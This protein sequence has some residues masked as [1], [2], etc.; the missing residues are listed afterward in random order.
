MNRRVSWALTA[1]VLAVATFAGW[2][3]WRAGRYANALEAS[4]QTA[5]AKS[6]QN[7]E[8]AHV[9]LGKV[10]V[11]SSAADR[12]SLLDTVWYESRSAADEIGRLPLG[13]VNLAATR[14]FLNQ[15]GDYSHVLARMVAAGKPVAREHWDTL[16]RLHTELGKLA[17][18][19]HKVDARLTDG[20]VRWTRIM[21]PRWNRVRRQVAE[22]WPSPS[23][24]TLA[25]TQLAAAPGTNTRKSD[26]TPPV[27]ENLR[28][29]TDIDQHLQELPAMV[30]DGPFSETVMNRKPLGLTG[31]PIT[32][33]QAV[34]RARSYL[35]GAGVDTRDFRVEGRVLDI[36]GRI[37]SYQVTFVPTVGRG[38]VHAAISKKGGHLVWLLNDRVVG[39]PRLTVTQAQDSARSYLKAK[40]FG[41]V[42]PTYTLREDNTLLITFVAMQGDIRLY[43][44]QIK[45][46]VALDNGQIVGVD[47]ASY[48]TSH[49]AR[50]LPKPRI[51]REEAARRA[52]ARLTIKQTRLAVIPLESTREVLAWENSG[53]LGGDTYLVYINAITGEEER[54]LQVIKT[55]GGQLTM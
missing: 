46:R 54:V 14:Q 49:H 17:S 38:R 47:A 33:Q 20:G 18:G 28:G 7:V 2:Q 45:V 16:T 55:A 31:A 39:T 35:D 42:E 19:L 53:D 36:N 15:A 24:V 37:P 50:D 41:D 43:P 23:P 4:Y 1:L 27:P 13:D 29:F 34:D 11:A 8:S 9:A 40:G 26:I 25:S 21:N 6:L 32:S 3:W 44:D 51:T 30:Y 12:A 5:F 22:L 48:L 52:Q 10:L